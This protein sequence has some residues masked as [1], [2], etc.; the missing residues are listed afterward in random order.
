MLARA[1]C[2]LSCPGGRQPTNTLGLL[3]GPLD[4]YSA[5]EAGSTTDR[6]LKATDREILMEHLAS[7]VAA[8]N[9]GEG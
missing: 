1:D 4:R 7:L 5:S 9:E 3:I 8:M 6:E 2:A